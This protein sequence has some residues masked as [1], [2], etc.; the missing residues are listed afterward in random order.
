[1]RDTKNF[2]DSKSDE[3][4]MKANTV[5]RCGDMTRTRYLIIQST[6]FKNFVK[7]YSLL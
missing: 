3:A 7:G 1:M 2:D 4:S 6:F 5:A